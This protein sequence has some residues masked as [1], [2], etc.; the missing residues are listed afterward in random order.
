MGCKRLSREGSPKKTRTGTG[1]LPSTVDRHDLIALV[2]HT[3]E[4][5]SVI[6]RD[7]VMTLGG[8]PF[9]VILIVQ[10][11]VSAGHGIIHEWGGGVRGGTL[12]LK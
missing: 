12:T 7:S 10:M 8:K 4:G 11:L 1:P 3:R 9:L 2:L 6:T 5:G